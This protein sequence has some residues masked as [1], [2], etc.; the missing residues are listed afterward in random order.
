M[1]PATYIELVLL[2][3]GILT[4]AYGQGVASGPG[5]APPSSPTALPGQP[6][7]QNQ[8]SMGTSASPGPNISSRSANGA[9]GANSQMNRPS[10]PVQPIYQNSAAVDS[11]RGMNNIAG[12]R[13]HSMMSNDQAPNESRANGD[14]AQRGELG[15]WLVQSGGPG[16]EI[17]RITQNS[18]ADRAGLRAGDVILQVNGRGAS[19]PDSTARMI[20]AIP[21]GQPVTISIWRDGNQQEMQVAMEPRRETHQVGY[22]GTDDSSE[23]G[24]SGGNVSERISR[25]EQQIST[26]TEELQ[27]LRRQQSPANANG[28]GA[29][30][31][32]HGAAGG[33]MT[34]AGAGAPIPTTP[35]TA[36]AGGAAGPNRNNSATPNANPQPPAAGPNAN[37]QSDSLF[38]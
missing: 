16:V 7:M 27:R 19:S 10:G 33:Q 9:G 35:P 13:E 11:R 34:G 30:A 20:R 6:G 15:V 28:P 32:G 17:A 14:S 36:G 2:L 3:L 31:A 5:G 23:N 25:L 21:I 26:M 37:T 8:Q 24:N 1:K 38:Q 29:G 12:S 18:A 4:D 22:R